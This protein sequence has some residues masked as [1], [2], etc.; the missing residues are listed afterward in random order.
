M[1]RKDQTI[2][3]NGT[4]RRLPYRCEIDGVWYDYGEECRECVKR[5]E[6]ILHCGSKYQWGKRRALSL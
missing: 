2:D 5:R 3:K 6:E 4:I 1:V